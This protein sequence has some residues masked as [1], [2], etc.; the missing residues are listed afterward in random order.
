[1]ASFIV[2]SSGGWYAESPSDTYTSFRQ[3]H[4][5]HLG[6][7]SFSATTESLEMYNWLVDDYGE[8]L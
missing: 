8:K 5:Q 1:M 4:Q 7:Y 6:K 2:G 3:R